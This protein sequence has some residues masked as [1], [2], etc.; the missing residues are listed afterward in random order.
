MEGTVRKIPVIV[1]LLMFAAAPAGAR[2]AQRAG[3][4]EP[5]APAAEPAVQELGVQPAP[6]LELA[7]PCTLVGPKSLLHDYP[8]MLADGTVTALVEIPAGSVDKWE[9]DKKDGS[10]RWEIRDG[11]PRK[12]RYLGYPVNYGMVPR[13]VLAKEHGGDGDPL[14]VLVLGASLPRGSVLPVRVVAM[15]RMID[16]GE[17]DDKLVAVREGT[18][19]AEIHNLQELQQLFPGITTILETWFSNYKGQGVTETRGFADVDAARSTLEATSRWFE[20]KNKGS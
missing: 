17:R 11:K 6:G 10:L 19:F 13:T 3:A 1:L 9:T 16:R 20:E 7:D 14:D 8:A 12:V 2:D 5:Q 18:P 4:Q 15:M